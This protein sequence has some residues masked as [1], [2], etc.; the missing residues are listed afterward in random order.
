MVISTRLHI[1]SNC[2]WVSSYFKRFIFSVWRLC[3]VSCTIWNLPY[4]RRHL[5]GY[6]HVYIFNFSVISL[7]QI[8]SNIHTILMSVKTIYSCTIIPT[9]AINDN[10][11]KHLLLMLTYVLQKCFITQY[12]SIDLLP[13]ILTEPLI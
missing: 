8:Y 5:P 13:L 3:P 1:L 6:V 9:H 2:S 4:K 11:S 7:I 10:T 12:Y